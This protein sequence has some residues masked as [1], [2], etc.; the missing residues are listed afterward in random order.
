VL[1]N[2]YILKNNP[3]R[4]IANDFNSNN[5]TIER[6]RVRYN[7]TNGTNDRP[8]CGRPQVTTAR[9]NML[10]VRQHFNRWRT[11]SALIGRWCVPTVCRAVSVALVSRFRKCW[12][13]INMFWRA[14]VTCGLPQ[15]GR[16]FVM[17]V[18]L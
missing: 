7:A 6:L 17:F 14:V 13:T 18:A 2:S 3:A 11:V 5:R 12:R 10:M 1:I 8:R 9:Q 16:S 4:V 15:R